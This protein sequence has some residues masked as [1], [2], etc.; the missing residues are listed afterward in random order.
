LV[1]VAAHVGVLLLSQACTRVSCGNGG[2]CIGKNKCQCINNWKGVN[3][4]RA[5]NPPFVN[6]SNRLL[7]MLFALRYFG[8]VRARL[9]WYADFPPCARREHD[10][11]QAHLGCSNFC[12]LA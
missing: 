3:C 11:D 7:L 2:A 10:H 1:L 4:E 8:C 6:A 5:F 9:H 12:V